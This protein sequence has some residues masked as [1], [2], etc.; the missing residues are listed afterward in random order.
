LIEKKTRLIKLKN[1]SIVKF[2]NNPDYIYTNMDKIR[3][4]AGRSNLPLCERIS[5]YI[6]IPLTNRKI[7]VFANGEIYVE[8]LDNIRGTKVFF[9]QTGISNSIAS[10]NNYLLE[11]L[12]FA[13]CCK[14]SG[15]KSFTVIYPHF[16]YA[17]SDKKT[18][19]RESIMASVVLNLLKTVGCDRIICMDIHAFQIQGMTDMPFDNLYAINNLHVEN[20]QKNIISCNESSN[21]VLVIFYEIKTTGVN[22]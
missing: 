10:I 7:D 20:I 5:K 22:L 4:I 2:F 15:V 17:R 21:Y 16:P 3:L 19:P 18:K 12:Q 1:K 13:D 8:I 9:V 14:R 11:I 6:D